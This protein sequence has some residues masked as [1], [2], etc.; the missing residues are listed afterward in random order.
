[1]ARP[2]TRLDLVC[3]AC[4]IE[5]SRMP[6]ERRK[7]DY[8]SSACYHVGRLKHRQGPTMLALTCGH[9]GVQFTRRKGQEREHPFCSQACYLASDYHR[10]LVGEANSRRNPDAKVT[11]P[12]V[13]CGVDVERYLSSRG[14]QVFC[15]RDCHDSYRR[16]RQT[17]HVTGH[18][19]VIMYVGRDYPNATKTGHILEHRKVMQ[20]ILGRP[21]VEA[22]NVHHINGV[23]GDNR[24]G[25]LELWS[26][27]QPRGQRVKDK[28]RW[29]R[30]FLAL[31]ESEE[32]MSTF[33]NV[34]TGVVVSVDDSKDDRYADGSWAKV[35]APA[36]K[37]E[38][39]KAA[40]K[41]TA[42]KR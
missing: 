23:R 32:P 5:F 37:A 17:K 7:R 24:P 22:E 14:K 16:A 42:T 39:K 36:K 18:G 12:C 27:S 11:E 38:P 31:Y 33:R 6:S 34:T 9:C 28:I 21:L 29:A 25:N 30:E 41:S 4:G 35:G 1:M 13:Y 2:S 19:Y 26:R 3:E 20:D 10:H 15:S 8:C 40:A